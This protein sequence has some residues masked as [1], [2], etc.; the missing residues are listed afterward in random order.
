MSISELE[1]RE[2]ASNDLPEV[3]PLHKTAFQ[4]SLG[5][6]LGDHYVSAFLNWFL[7]NSTAIKLGCTKNKRLVG[8]VFGSPDGYTTK[9]NH[10]LFGTVV[11]SILTHP[12]LI[13][14]SN[15]VAQIP[16]R[17]RSL[18]GISRSA[19][20]GH[21]N[22][23][24]PVYKLVGIGTDPAFRRLGIGRNLVTSFEDCVWSEGYKE[25]HLSVYRDNQAA[26]ALYASCGWREIPT[27]P[28]TKVVTMARRL[29]SPS[30]QVSN[31]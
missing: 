6:G 3:I 31:K 7:S 24:L 2:L 1:V 13:V 14:R 16:S 20:E 18:L 4:N 21:P 22:N 12:W 8:Y 27:N 30:I 10:D 26:Q 17:L 29:D 23:S 5:V 9:L 15:F 11:L 19:S 25:I 28:N